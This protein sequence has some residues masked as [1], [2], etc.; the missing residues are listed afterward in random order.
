LNRAKC[1]E[2]SGDISAALIDLTKFIELEPL[3]VRGY[4][5]RAAVYDKIGEKEKAE[6]DRQ[7]AT[8]LRKR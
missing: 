5:G 3:D 2:L 4:D 8:D 1:F 7:K 6:A